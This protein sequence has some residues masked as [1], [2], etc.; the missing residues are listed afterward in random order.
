M[1]DRARRPAVTK[2]GL[3]RAFWQ[4]FGLFL[5]L[6][7]LTIDAK[8]GLPGPRLNLTPSLPRGLYFYVPGS[9][10]IGDTVQACLPARL[11]QFA[12]EHEILMRGVCPHD[13]EPIVKVL[14]AAAGDTVTVTT[15]AVLVNGR[16]WPDSAIRSTDSSGRPVTMR[17]PLGA[18]RLA[19]NDV[20]LLGRSPHSWD[21]R[22]FGFLP[23]SVVT[24]RWFPLVT[25]RGLL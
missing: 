14:A 16:A 19:A 11:A 7:L 1:T 22:Y 18:R 3:E 5:L 12:R 8:Y 24:G 17:M 25:E 4:V 2:R 23:R 20:L 6:M 10:K 9:V 21:G 15:A 13:V